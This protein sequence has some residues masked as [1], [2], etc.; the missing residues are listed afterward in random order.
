M[1]VKARLNLRFDKRDWF[2]F[3]AVTISIAMVI[4]GDLSSAVSFIIKLISK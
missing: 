3:I 2:Y 4:R 1:R